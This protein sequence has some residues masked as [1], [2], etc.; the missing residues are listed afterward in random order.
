[1]KR[2]VQ[3]LFI[4]IAI[5]SFGQKKKEVAATKKVDYS[6][7]I[8]PEK[9]EFQE[10]K[11][12][13]ADYKGMKAMKLAPN[14]GQVVLKDVIFKDGTIEYDIEPVA[15]EFAES[16]YFHR[17]D[18][19]EQE[20]VYLRLGSVGNKLGNGGIQYTP[21]FDGV[22]MWDM[23][24][25]YQAPAMA[26][27]GE[28]NHFKLIV[29]GKRLQ[30]FLNNAQKPVLDIPELEGSMSEGSIAFEGSSYIA[31][32]QVKPN[33]V[34]NL[35]PLALPDL[36]DHDGYYLR[37]WALTAPQ[38]L[39]DG[40]ELSTKTMPQPELFTD[41]I[42]AER[43][44]LVNLTRKYGFSK[45]RRVVWL[46]TKIVA[47]EA[48]KTDL[49]LG[50]SDEVWVFLNN[51]MILVDKNLFSQ[52]MKKYPDG[53]ISVLNTSAQMNLRKGENDLLIGVSNDFY[54]WGIMAR[55]E[56]GEGIAE[57]DNISS[58]ARLAKEIS[59]LELEPYAG[60]YSSTE[61]TFKLTFA[62]KGKVL[63]A[64]VSGQEPVEMQTLG[65]HSFAYRAGNVIFEFIPDSKKVILRQGGDSKVFVRE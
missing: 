42:A 7:S 21:Y 1:M 15:P 46:K 56:S 3:I 23:Y 6:V 13:F 40:N 63:S 43:R 16:V 52:N 50:F 61:M 59:T 25:E 20:I 55:L 22:N 18:L 60:T 11:V 30:V 26:R 36:T 32:V 28:W 64:Q 41:S 38:N 65:N 24:S 34:E 31:N 12:T 17:K 9:W 48:V 47:K 57:T 58:I 49:Q 33:Q 10:G 37:K 53:R 39:P 29:S 4:L 62:K 51:Q 27:A 54:G 2:L 35:S 44:G 5:Q 19:K 45:D 14:S 8:T